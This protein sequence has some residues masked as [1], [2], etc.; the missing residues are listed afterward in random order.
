MLGNNTLG[1]R[2]GAQWA[3]TMESCRSRGVGTRNALR[4]CA[5]KGEPR[6]RGNSD[7]RVLLTGRVVTGHI[8]PPRNLERGAA[9]KSRSGVMRS[10]QQKAGPRMGTLDREWTPNFTAC[11]GLRNVGSLG[12]ESIDLR[13]QAAVSWPR[14][15]SDSGSNAFPWQLGIRSEPMPRNRAGMLSAPGSLLHEIRTKASVE[16]LT[17]EAQSPAS[18]G[19]Q[20]HKGVRSEFPCGI[21][22]TELANE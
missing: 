1:T 21:Q 18:S 5:R 7:V 12:T 16:S 14:C 11:L 10:Q 22:L 20:I 2:H 6:L 3:A 19:I 17:F 4:L 9:A 8:R 15:Y 13:R